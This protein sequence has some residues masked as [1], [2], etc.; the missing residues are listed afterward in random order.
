MPDHGRK[1]VDDA[2]ATA[3][4]TGLW[5]VVADCIGNRDATELR[6]L[7]VLAV[8]AMLGNMFGE[9]LGVVSM[10]FVGRLG[11]D[12]ISSATLAL[13]FTNC[14][15]QAILWGLSGALDT[16]CSQAWGAGQRKQVGEA[17][18]RA[19]LILTI[20][21]VPILMLWW[22][23]T[24]PALALLGLGLYCPLNVH[25]RTAGPRSVLPTGCT[26]TRSSTL[27]GFFLADF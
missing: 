9:T 5:R 20:L 21:C 27:L 7:M 11:P 17:F 8:P 16:Q 4:A 10:L 24:E 18:Q 19:V 1:P 25:P 15:G 12:A 26:C 22:T 6:A 13:M 14:S 2:A 3:N 23:C